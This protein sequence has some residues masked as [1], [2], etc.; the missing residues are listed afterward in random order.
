MFSFSAYAGGLADRG[1]SAFHQIPGAVA[2]VIAIFLPGILLIYFVYPVWEDLK[3]IR[4]IRVALRGIA[5]VAAG[6]IAVAA[7]IL[8]QRSGFSPDNILVFLLTGGL[9][10]SG[11]IPAPLLVAGV[12]L[13]GFTF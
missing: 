4:G 7:L 1:G 6:L 2:G 12:L 3:E 11:R 10:L 5:P 9:L 13:A 8:M